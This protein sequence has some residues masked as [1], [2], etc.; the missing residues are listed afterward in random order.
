[1]ENQD[2]RWHQRY[3]NYHKALIRLEEA[4]NMVNICSNPENIDLLKEGLIQRFEFTQELAWKVMKDYLEYQ[5]ET[6]ISGSRDAFRKALAAD[7]INNPLWIDTI[8]TRNITSHTYDDDIT[9]TIYDVITTQ[10][11]PLMKEFDTRM[12]KIKANE[13]Q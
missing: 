4:A 10:Y 5:G 7:L 3:E 12:K 8:K 2:I 1:M 6:G 11:L 9:S 13:D